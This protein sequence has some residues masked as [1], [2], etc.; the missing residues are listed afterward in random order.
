[1]AEIHIQLQ[2]C[3][4]FEYLVVNDD[5]GAAVTQF[6]AI[7]IANLLKRERRSSWVERFKA[8]AHTES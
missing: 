6:S 1:M 5:L 3:A 2:H 4:H 8:P 7:F